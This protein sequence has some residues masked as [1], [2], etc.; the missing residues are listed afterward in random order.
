MKIGRSVWTG[1]RG[2]S[3][4]VPAGGVHYY[5]PGEYPS[6][7]FGGGGRIPVPAKGY[8][9]P[10]VQL[11]DLWQDQRLGR[12]LEQVKLCMKQNAK[13]SDSDQWST[14]MLFC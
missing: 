12:D 13:M 9:G 11:Q 14:L 1:R 10:G 8:P 2:R 6:L 5:Q 4:L 7:S 3:T